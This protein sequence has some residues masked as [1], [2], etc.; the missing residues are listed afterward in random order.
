[1]GMLHVER[2]R[3]SLARLLAESPAIALVCPA[4]PPQ[5]I[6]TLTTTDAAVTFAQAYDR[7]HVLAWLRAPLDPPP[8]IIEVDAPSNAAAARDAHDRASGL[9]G[10]VHHVVVEPA[11][12]VPAAWRDLPDERR[13]LFLAPVPSTPPRFAL[14]HDAVLGPAAL[15]AIRA[16]LPAPTAAPTRRRARLAI[17][18]LA[19]LLAALSALA[20][21]LGR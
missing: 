4:D 9:F 21:A 16:A 13:L 12:D 20:L 2:D 17:A 11:L 1:M 15:D 5:R 7:F 10:H 19:A 8:P 6:A 18:L 3:V 14:V